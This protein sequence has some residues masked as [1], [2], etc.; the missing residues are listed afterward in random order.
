MENIRVTHK[1]T[2]LDEFTENYLIYST[3]IKLL[4]QNNKIVRL[5]D[6]NCGA[7]IPCTIM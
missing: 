2:N 5:E 1:L 6:G 3:K 7:F 4:N